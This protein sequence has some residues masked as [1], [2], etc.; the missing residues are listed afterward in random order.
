M[1]PRINLVIACWGGSRRTPDTKYESDR[2]HYLK[3]QVDSLS[4][5]RH[6]L[7]EVT[8]V[9][10]GGDS[11][12]Y[13]DYLDIIRKKYKVID[14]P[15]IGMSYGMFDAAW[16]VDRTYDYYIFL[17][18][19]F[20]FVRND[21]DIE[22]VKYFESLD[23]CGYLCQLAWGRAV[24]HPAIFNGIASRECL[25]RLDILPGGQEYSENRTQYYGKVES[26]G[27]R[28][29]GSRV[30]QIGLKVLDMG[31][32][33]RAPF[34]EAD[35]SMI[36]WHPTAR[37]YIIAP[38]QMYNSILDNPDY[39]EE[40]LVTDQDWK[41]FQTYYLLLRGIYLNEEARAIFTANVLPCRMKSREDLARATAIY[42]GVIR[43]RSVV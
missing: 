4:R 40:Y 35:G 9:S 19:D 8:F 32:K 14:R 30:Q 20:V 41:A 39:I 6:S 38:V 7:T 16:Q 43:H 10:N 21:F 12:A 22:M 13:F 29:W 31:R 34:I 27:Q 5:F 3:H 24:P 28:A 26:A 17:E 1:T 37:H 18:D 36:C 33:F 42:E 23:N 2:S 15:N 11:Q 25:N